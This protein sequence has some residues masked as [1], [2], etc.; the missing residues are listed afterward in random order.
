MLIYYI[1]L[2]KGSSKFMSE[3]YNSLSNVYDKLIDDVDYKSL[4]KYFLKLCKKNSHK[5]K[6]VLDAACG[7]GNFTKELI[8]N[9]LDVI[10]VDNSSEMLSIA[11]EKLGG[12]CALICQDLCELDLY[13]TID[14]VFCTLDALN[15]ITD[16]ERFKLALKK[17]ALFLEPGGLMFFDVNTVYKHEKILANNIFTDEKENIYLVWQNS[18]YDDN[19]V[20]INMDFFIKQ[21]D[22]KYLRTNENFDERAYTF[23]QIDVALKDA[24]LEVIDIKDFFTFGDVAENS[25][26]V[27]YIVKK[28]G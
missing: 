24:K 8:D 17:M 20:N 22:G 16:Y 6:L 9:G 10:G 19:I 15:H 4:C 7:T 25:E 11:S 5:P 27:I 28:G 3:N 18:L 23:D 26:K 14:T 12:K 21:N 1:F 13:G 2:A